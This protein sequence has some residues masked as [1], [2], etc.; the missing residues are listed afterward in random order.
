VTLYRS[1][2]GTW[3]DFAELIQLRKMALDSVNVDRPELGYEVLSGTTAGT[4]LFL[5]P[6]PSL[7]AIDSGM[8]RTPVYA[9]GV[10]QAA[11]KARKEISLE[12]DVSREHFLFRVDPRIS[13]VSE[14]FAAS[15]PEFWHG[16]R[17]GTR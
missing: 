13:F 15:N 12:A 6:L 1:R 17:S 4:Y 8:A 14:S 5:A 9:E 7:K 2:P 3:Q 11:S 16:P 10:A